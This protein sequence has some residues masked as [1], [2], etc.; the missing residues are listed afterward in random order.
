MFRSPASL[1][2]KLLYNLTL[3]S[4]SLEQ[5]LG[6]TWD[7]SPRLEALNIPINII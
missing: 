3:S 4:A 5:F 6:T 7:L 2:C 1:C